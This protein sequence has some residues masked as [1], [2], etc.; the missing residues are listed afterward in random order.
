MVISLGVLT[1]GTTD[2]DVEL[3][4]NSLE[5]SLLSSKQRQVDV[6]RSAEGSAEVGG[7]GGNVAQLG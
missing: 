6:D 7:A 4:S 1:M 3:I 5:L 2:L